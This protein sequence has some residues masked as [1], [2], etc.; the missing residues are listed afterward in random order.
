MKKSV[1]I[2]CSI[3]I[4]LLLGLY[5][6]DLGNFWSVIIGILVI[7]LIA[8][9]PFIVNSNYEKPLQNLIKKSQK[10]EKGEIEILDD[11][12]KNKN[13]Q[14]VDHSL[15]LLTSSIQNALS[16]ISNLEKGDYETEYQN[17]EE[18]FDD[19]LASSLVNLRDKLKDIAKQDKIRNWATEGLAKFV[20]ILR[21]VGEEG[22]D[23]LADRI[24][25][26]LVKYVNA[27][28]GQL[29][30]F[31]DDNPDEP[32][33]ELIAFYAYERKKYNKIYIDTDSGLIGQAFREKDTIHLKEVPQDFVL[34]T[35]GL[36]ESTPSNVLIVP[37]KVNEDVFGIIEIASFNEFQP[38]EIEFIEKLGESIASTIS[39]ARL[40]ERTRKLL[41]DS[42]QQS[43]ELRAQEE[44]MRQ[45]M[46][47]LEATQEELK[48]REEEY[49]ARIKELEEE[50]SKIKKPK[51][52]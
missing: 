18:K 40:N 48:R 35:S 31:N 15:S 8:S 14:R 39:T 52:K 46:E 37:L 2:I 12:V 17:L 43:E 23:S 29:F 3:I 41:E 34:V 10:I 21:S 33:L 24:L 26:N 13:L 9:I 1:I 20:D 51:S 5:L 42:R 7:T 4:F 30:M 36:G 25:S 49:M 32:T 11:R 6:L 50:V 27:N 19:K 16:F 44:E 22:L 47:E 38:Y 45:N 28:Q